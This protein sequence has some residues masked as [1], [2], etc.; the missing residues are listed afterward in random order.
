MRNE[1]QIERA[2]GSLASVTQVDGGRE[3]PPP[4]EVSKAGGVTPGS[5]G[6]GRARGRIAGLDGLRGIAALGVVLFHFTVCYEDYWS[7]HAPVPFSL[8]FGMY[9]VQLF[10]LISG[11]V[12]FMTVEKTKN[13]FEFAKL[14]VARL[15]PAFWVSLA[16]TAAVI[17]LTPGPDP[18]MGW[19]RLFRRIVVNATM[20]PDW[21]RVTALNS[22][23]W[24]LAVEMTFYG[25]MFVLLATR[26]L[27]WTVP[28]L[29]A[30][31]AIG[32]IDGLIVAR[33][34]N[35]VSPWLRAWLG[36]DYIHVI[37]IGVLIYKM[38]ETPRPAYLALACACLFLPYTQNPQ[39][40]APGREVIVTAVAA[41]VM[42]AATNGW[43]RPLQWKPLVFLG[44]VSYS[45]YLNHMVLGYHIIYNA[46]RL[47]LSPLASILIA[48]L[49]GILLATAITFLVE[50]PIM[51][52]VKRRRAAAVA[53]VPT[54]G[55]REDQATGVAT[56]PDEFPTR[57]LPNRLLTSAG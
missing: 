12:I 39:Y 13:P 2:G 54:P 36:L 15:Y 52:A 40:H 32:A 11:F 42:V 51:A 29:A 57:V 55:C 27:R 20:V 44:T 16:I 37:L 3:C 8:P 4:L 22:V 46:R 7:F 14:R 21:F 17:A 30:M 53:G 26:K 23:Y 34:P 9:G 48:T 56:N 43:I 45:L 33:W 10:F 50:L 28:T 5:G 31:A 47:G 18:F 25:V 49:V 19:G 38:R 24:T 6:A 35:P 1:S 41:L